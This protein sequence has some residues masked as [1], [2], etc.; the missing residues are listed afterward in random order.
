MSKSMEGDVVNTDD[1]L[2]TLAEWHN[3]VRQ[4]SGSAF[5]A[6]EDIGDTEGAREQLYVDLCRLGNETAWMEEQVSRLRAENERLRSEL[7]AARGYLLNAKIDLE[8]GAP[9]RTA[10][11]TINGGLERL[12]RN[13]KEPSN[14]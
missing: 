8:T 2:S 7:D 6:G 5:V 9:K 10:I 13:L 4:W 3:T 14:G 1:V 11:S 12:M